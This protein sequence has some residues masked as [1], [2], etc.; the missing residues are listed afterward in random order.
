MAD[1][2]KYL[3]VLGT[4]TEMEISGKDVLQ[5]TIERF[6]AVCPDIWV[7]TVLPPVRIPAWR[8][9]CMVRNFNHR[10]SL[11]AAGFT[12]FHSVR[13]ALEKVPDGALVI[14]HDGDR[15]LVRP[16]LITGMLRR[17]AEGA[18][19]LVP[20]LP[21]RDAVKRVREDSM[22][23]IPSGEEPVFLAQTPQ[24]YLSEDIKAAYADAYDFSLS[25][26]SSVVERKN[27]PL[28][29][30]EGEWLNFKVLNREDLALAQ[31]VID[32]NN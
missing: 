9:Y 14:I 2:R 15:P 5:V 18:R 29:P 12:P 11:V 21:S 22:E 6:T 13:K 24:M 17:M 1:R 8:S 20:V 23:D 7:I 25:D 32:G 27:I 28:T 31:A 16:A 19:A 4:E 26:A 3:V 30:V 10:Q